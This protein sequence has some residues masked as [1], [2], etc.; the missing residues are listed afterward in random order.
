[1]FLAVN[2]DKLLQLT[3]FSPTRNTYPK[4]NSAAGGHV[5]VRKLVRAAIV[6]ASLIVTFG[7]PALATSVVFVNPGK[8]GETFWDMVTQTMKAAARQLGLSVEVLYAER[9]HRSMQALGIEVAERQTKPEFLILVNEE[10]AAR[11]I[12][13]A[14]DRNGLKTLLISNSLTGGDAEAVGGPRRS[15]KSWLGSVIPDMEQAGARMANALIDSARTNGRVSS[16]GK[17]HLFAIGGDEVTPSSIARNRGFHQAVSSHSDVVVDRFL[18]ANWNKADAE[19]VTTAYLAWAQ[20]KGIQV[21]GIWA[22]NDPMALGAMSAAEK[23]GLQ[24]GKDLAVV[25]LN[26]SKEAL[27]EV[28]AG[29]MLLTDG[30]HFLAGAW[31][32]VVLSDYIDGCDFAEHQTEL[33]FTTSAV[34]IANLAS[35]R[36]L[37][38]NQRMNEIDF[39]SFT[40]RRHG[41]C[42]V[43]D[44]SLDAVVSAFRAS[45]TS[46]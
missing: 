8:K 10:A 29:R 37:I 39:R 40:A 19:A 20:R 15:L 21:A 23:A 41:R 34:S 46:N 18:F 24:A 1:M 28:A 43:Y 6:S 32:M 14:A 27:S 25:G 45:A 7:Q 11:P 44:F 17:I 5:V 35:V 9:N 36:D 13:A 42:G 38:E 4:L 33:R 26:W 12:L 3:E 16:D 22:A 31:A 2:E 30:G